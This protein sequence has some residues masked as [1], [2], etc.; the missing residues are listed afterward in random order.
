[1][2]FIDR[3]LI[4]RRNSRITLFFLHDDFFHFCFSALFFS[5]ANGLIAIGSSRLLLRNR[6]A[7]RNILAVFLEARIT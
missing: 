2:E 7:L 3:I 6:Y 1:M 4:L 5:Q